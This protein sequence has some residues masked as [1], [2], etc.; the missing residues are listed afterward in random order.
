MHPVHLFHLCTPRVRQSGWAIACLCALVLSQPCP[1]QE[2]RFQTA[3]TY[4]Q[5]CRDKLRNLDD[6]TNGLVKNLQSNKVDAANFRIQVTLYRE[7]LRDMMLA[8]QKTAATEQLPRPLLMDL[9]RM[10]AL[11][12]SAANCET[13]RYLVCPADLMERILLQQKAVASSIEKFTQS[14]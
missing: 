5:A 6:S 3:Q 9:V 12:Q 4:T 13:G 10:A 1:A 7:S 8:D 11:L 2:T 14:E